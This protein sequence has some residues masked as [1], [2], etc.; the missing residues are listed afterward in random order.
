LNAALP[1]QWAAFAKAAPEAAMAE[2]L[3]AAETVDRLIAALPE[4]IPVVAILSERRSLLDRSI[5][6][7]EHLATLERV[8]NG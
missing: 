4:E 7:H 6:R 5:H 3:T 2:V 1:A 8:L